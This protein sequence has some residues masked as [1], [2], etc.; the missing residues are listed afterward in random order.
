MGVVYLALSQGPGGFTKL[1]VIKRLRPEIAEEPRALQMFLD[2]AKLAARLL[3]PN[4]VQ[5]NEVGF[6]GKHYFLEMEYLEGQP[7][8]A[9]VR[10]LTAK[11]ARVPLADALWI[12]TQTLAGLHYAHELK[13]LDGTPLHV[14]HR[15][16]SP[17]NVFVTYEGNVKVLDFGIAK[18]A[19]SQ[20]ET[21]TGAVK[22]KATYMAPEQAAKRA[23]DRRADVF[24]VG[25]MLWE[26][27]AGRR[28]WAGLSD[29]EIFLKL[30]DEPIPSPKTVDATV[31]P[32]L[33]AICMKAV[34]KKPDDRWATAAEMQ[35]ALEEH[36]ETTGARAGQ[37]TVT[38]L[39]TELFAEKRAQVKAEI[40]SRTKERGTSPQTFEIPV[41]G[42]TGTPPVT[43]TA[44]AQ[45]RTKSDVREGAQVRREGR[46]MRAAIGAAVAVAVVAGGVAI[47]V[48]MMRRARAKADAA[49]AAASASAA[50]GSR[51]CEKN[52]QC[53]SAH[54]G[55]AW[56]CRKDQGRCVSLES[57]DCKVLAE[58]G[59][60]ENDGTIWFGTMF[61]TTGPKGP[62]GERGERAA[63][64]GRRDFMEMT[65]GL[66]S[67]SADG[68]TR[69]LALIACNDADQP[70]RSAR[71]LAD[72]V[73][74]PAVI[75]FGSSQEVVDLATTIFMPKRVL[76][77]AS[78]NQAAFVTS[79]PQ[80]AGEPRLVWRT[81]LSTVHYQL[82]RAAIVRDLLEPRIRAGSVGPNA[83]IRVA[84]VRPKSSLGISISNELL[85]HL[86]FNGADIVQNE[87][88]FKE[89]VVNDPSDYAEAVTTL[90]AWRP[91]IVMYESADDDTVAD[92]LAP[93]ESRWPKGSQSPPYFLLGTSVSDGVS[94]FRL[95]GSDADRRR[96]Y[97]GI[98]PPANTVLNL[99]FTLRYNETFSQK[100]T[101]NESPAA[102]YD[103]FYLL[104]YAAFAADGHPPTGSD[105]A[106]A[107]PRL[108][109]PGE[110]VDVGA[111]PILAALTELR[112]GKNI[113]LRGAQTALD[114]DIATGEPAGDM[115]VQCVGTDAHGVA[116]DG[117]D[118]GMIYDGKAGKL[119]G[120]LKCP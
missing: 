66:P 63:D 28:L 7:Y 9:L 82:A 34:A 48:V 98:A 37:K 76:A 19:D 107:I 65:H 4:V 99:K 72:D 25:V 51:E 31:S 113:D 88:N 6:D 69:P 52:A 58:P 90:V 10:R 120:T 80:P 56:I 30:Q 105:L 117:I 78:A 74:V 70:Q 95:I 75:G 5:T 81:N 111:G 68:P 35:A 119:T 84:L 15:D 86:H 18:A 2:E 44:G 62:L 45:V 29:F 83:P 110:E 50:A 96:R 21:T 89:V 38:K 112:G 115:V 106:R 40:E 27:L 24:A 17:H 60:V 79:V 92:F 91:H 49:A 43:G 12:L 114:F 8:D 46:A 11:G 100:I 13:D 3:H 94:I 97:F 1:K 53:T 54:G 42:E 36:L 109:P 118:S 23:A 61:P 32:E 20:G 108:L 93:L 103:S 67:L 26:A 59:D 16:V 14:V 33:E 22:G 71:H 64:L 104:A 73:G 77:I 47:G 116:I 85:P 102:P 101:I 57:E 39:M 41:I 87:S 55:G